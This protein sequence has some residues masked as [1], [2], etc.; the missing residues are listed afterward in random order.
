[1]TKLN[2]SFWS[3]TKTLLAH[4][5]VMAFFAV[6]LPA[7][8]FAATS[9]AQVGNCNPAPADGDLIL[10]GPGGT[11]FAFRPVAVTGKGGPVGGV[12]FIMGD[13]A[14]DFKTPPTAVVV[15]GAF[16]ATGKNGPDGAD[17]TW[18]YYLGKYELTQAQ[19]AAVM[20]A[21]KPGDKKAPD[22]S[23]D[24][25]GDMPVTGISYF[26]AIRFC[27]ALNT[28][29]Y[30]HALE[31][32]PESGPYPGFIRLPTEAE[33]E[34]AARG[35]AAVEATV[36]DAPWPYGDDIA[37]FEWFSGPTS[38]H[39]KLQ[40]VGKLKAN[41]LGLHDML[42]NVSEIT[43]S[44]Y[45]LEYYQGRS[46]GFT[47]RGG[48]YLTAEDKLHT[49]LRSEEP[50]YLGS[51]DKG[52]RPNIKPTMGFRLALSAPLL[53]DRETIAEIKDAWEGFREGPGA[54][55]PAALSVADVG[56]R[57]AV[58]AQEALSRLARIKQELEKAGLAQSLKQDMAAT[59]A[60]LR[61]M[62][63][64]RRQADEDSARVWAK[65]AGERGLFLARNL[66]GLAVIKDVSSETMRRRA[67]QFQYNI[68]AGLENYGEIMSE[69]A[70]LPKDA[71]LKGFD[72]YAASLQ[73]KIV[74]T[75]GAD[76]EE[77]ALR[78]KDISGQKDLL[79]IT[80]AHYERYEKEKRFDAAAWRADYAAAAKQ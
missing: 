9:P 44:H 51:T 52:M 58:P 1:M 63:Q 25:P 6:F 77:K 22:L 45:Y 64:V 50:Y 3:G 78:V 23:A 49:A 37:P 31:A 11:C 29:L 71:V 2:F 72:W 14:G 35:G 76:A 12:R 80:R 53:T 39:N 56:A 17:D 70:K 16:A 74:K 33:W 65:I 27:D 7:H 55:L 4:A 5:V 47:A 21:A 34:F 10:P 43:Q 57:E 18:L 79:A 20:G 32:L 59:E 54:D 48:H 46:G 8:S 66:R 73:S 28:W 62:A 61:S 15:G 60:A 24:M 40:A 36:F 75:D 69:L 38:S 30:E 19:Y 42:G 13:P 67:E 26:D 41:P 68:T